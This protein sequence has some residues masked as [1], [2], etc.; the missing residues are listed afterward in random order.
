M[1][2]ASVF[3]KDLNLA[4]LV[5]TETLPKTLECAVRFVREKSSRRFFLCV[6]AQV[7]KAAMSTAPLDAACSIDP[8]VRTMA[9]LFDLRGRS[10]EWATGDMMGKFMAHARKMDKLHTLWESLS[11]SKRRGVKRRW[12]RGL[13]RIRDWVTE[14]Q[15]KLAVYL[16]KNYRVILIPRYEVSDMVKKSDNTSGKTKKSAKRSHPAPAMASSLPQAPVASVASASV[17]PQA[18]PPK[19]RSWIRRIKSATVRGM[20]CWRPYEFRQRLKAK[21]ELYPGVTVVETEEPYTSKTCGCCGELHETLGSNKTFT[22]GAC[23]FKA[24]RDINGAR[25]IM[26]RFLSL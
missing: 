22:C 13:K 12:L 23:G 2:H 14:T 3:Y 1:G 16:C 5:A 11:G 19:P 24:D 26:L 8:G 9:T 10:L 7:K 15:C 21:A 18:P 17:P 25:N 6:P 4:K 20:L